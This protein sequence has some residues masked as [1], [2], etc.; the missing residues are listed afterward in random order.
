M[1]TF[2]I[3]I[4]IC[5]L[6]FDSFAQEKVSFTLGDK[7][8]S[9][10]AFRSFK[11]IPDNMSKGYYSFNGDKV[12][13][14]DLTYTEDADL[15]SYKKE[16]VLLTDLNLKSADIMDMS[17][18]SEGSFEGWLLSI[19][20]KKLKKLATHYMYTSFDPTS[21]GEKMPNINFVFNKKEDAEDFLKKLK[22]M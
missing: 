14:H 17:G 8:F 15:F 19:E 18:D 13:F 9:F 2:L 20:T 21:N 12:L 3:L 10:E 1:K 4:T 16:E 11:P 6:S 5:M 7:E 22:K